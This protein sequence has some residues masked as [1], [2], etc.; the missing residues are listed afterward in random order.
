MSLSQDDSLDRS[1]Y[2]EGTLDVANQVFFIIQ[3]HEDPPESDG[4]SSYHLLFLS[5]TDEGFTLV[6][7]GQGYATVP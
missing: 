6:P 5:L 7:F 1:E 3:E 2:S 4:S